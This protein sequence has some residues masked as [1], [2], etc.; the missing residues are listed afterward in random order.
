MWTHNLTDSLSTDDADTVRQQIAEQ[1]KSWFNASVTGYIGNSTFEVQEGQSGVVGW[2]QFTICHDLIINGD[3]GN[4]TGNNAFFACT[5]SVF[6][7]DGRYPRLDSRG[8]PQLDGE[9]RLVNIGAN[10][11]AG[12]NADPDA[13]PTAPAFPSGTAGVASNVRVTP[14]SILVSISAIVFVMFAC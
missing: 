13:T 10:S 2:T 5:P 6:G 7:Y 1:T 12:D 3:C 11:T 9:I 4:L 8:Y 14:T